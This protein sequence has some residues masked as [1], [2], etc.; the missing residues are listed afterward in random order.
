MT[1]LRN[2]LN[3]GNGVAVGVEEVPTGIR[4][5]VADRRELNTTPVLLPSARAALEVT[6]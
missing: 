3:G 1:R 4:V 6:P 5:A 2:R